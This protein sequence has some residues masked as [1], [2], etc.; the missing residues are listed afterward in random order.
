MEKQYSFEDF[1][2]VIDTLL[3]ENGC[4]WDREQTHESLLPNF[5]EEC[6]EV[7]DAAKNNDV[8]GLEEELGDVLL[9]IIMQSKIAEK[10]NLFNATDVITGISN[11]MINRHTHIFGG[12]NEKTV[13]EVLNNWDNVKKKEKGYE[14]NTQILKTIPKALPA[15]VRA[16]KIQKTAIKS[17]ISKGNI[18][19]T[20]NTIK[21]ALDTLKN[22]KNMEQNTIM[23]IFGNIIFNMVIIS[24][25]LEINA[26]FSLT[27][28]L[29]K[30]I[31]KFEHIENMSKSLPH[32][33]DDLTIGD[34]AK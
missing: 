23:E 30:F 34:L 4:P 6:Y 13:S 26:E 15:L 21:T 28:A 18:E 5:L 29:E 2:G 16:Q 27:N 17:G 25:F 9:H 12:T 32:S 7:I 31:T 20:I 33:T 3:G 10:E 14:N 22:T 19:D 24:C 11:K 1:C 8:K